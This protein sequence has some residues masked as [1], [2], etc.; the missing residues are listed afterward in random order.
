MDRKRRKRMIT[1]PLIASIQD[2]SQWN[3]VWWW[4]EH[5]GMSQ[6][7]LRLSVQPGKDQRLVPIIDEYSGRWGMIKKT[8][9]IFHLCRIHAS[10]PLFQSIHAD[11]A[12]KTSIDWPHA[13]KNSRFWEALSQ[14]LIISLQ[15]VCFIMRFLV[16]SSCSHSFDRIIK[17][18]FL[19]PCGVRQYM[20]LYDLCRTEADL[21]M[22]E[23]IGLVDIIDCG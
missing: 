5:G 16:Y 3:A 12:A 7:F 11:I 18:F 20:D 19:F 10:T 4:D 21:S 14:L 17:C 13:V 23:L 2:P 8:S 6:D 1:P 22:N 15:H 9:G